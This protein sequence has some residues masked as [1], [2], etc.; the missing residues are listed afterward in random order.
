MYVSDVRS[1]EKLTQSR[2]KHMR[3]QMTVESAECLWCSDAASR[4]ILL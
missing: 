1:F 3:F 2:C 4:S